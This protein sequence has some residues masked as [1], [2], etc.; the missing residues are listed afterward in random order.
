MFTSMLEDKQLE[1][2]VHARH[3]STHCNRR[4]LSAQ[5]FPARFGSQQKAEGEES[6]RSSP[7]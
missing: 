4:R 5:S 1:K 6:K 2:F 3:F 7:L